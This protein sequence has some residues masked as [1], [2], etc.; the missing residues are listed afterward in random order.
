MKSKTMI[1][2]VVAVVCG[3]VASYLTSQLIAQKNKKVNLVVAKKNVSQW[4]PI[5]NPEEL[6]ELREWPESDAP[7][8]AIGDMKELKDRV[9]LKDIEAEKPVSQTMLQDKAKVGL[10]G[11]LKPKT[12]GMA[13]VVNAASTAGGFILPG[14]KV[15]IVHTTRSAGGADTKLI[16]ENVL[17][18]AVD[19]QPVRP[20][21][22]ASQVPTTVTLE[23]SPEQSLKLCTYK[24]AG[25][26]TLLLRPF[27]DNSVLEASKDGAKPPE[28]EIAKADPITPKRRQGIIQTIINGQAQKDTKFVKQDKVYRTDTEKGG[29]DFQSPSGDSEGK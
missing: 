16:L 27:G 6:F 12:R 11:M 17:V 1:L 10:E 24:D 14:S 28:K 7:Q 20:E 23:L 5:K 15:D 18:V 21:D 3:L 29:S 19:Q 4:T 26:L 13:I 9:V 22:R 25:A 2:M 8:G